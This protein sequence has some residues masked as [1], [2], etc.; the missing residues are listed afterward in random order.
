MSE[1]PELT[2]LREGF[3]KRLDAVAAQA[4]KTPLGGDG[5][6]AALL[7][8]HGLEPIARRARD[9]AVG[10]GFQP[11]HG[12]LPI[13]LRRVFAAIQQEFQERC[14]KVVRDLQAREAPAHVL[15]QLGKFDLVMQELLDQRVAA[16]VESIRPK[17]ASLSGIFANAARTSLTFGEEKAGASTLKCK[18]CGAGRPVDTDLRECAFCGTPFFK[19]KEESDE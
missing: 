18:C 2:D 9:V 12:V 14:D 8:S 7:L 4:G 6:W 10:F 16:Y 3:L 19:T 1:A 15:N 5:E 11:T 13:E 17:A